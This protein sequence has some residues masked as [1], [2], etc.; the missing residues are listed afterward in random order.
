M[1]RPGLFGLLKEIKS[2]FSLLKVML[3]LF[4]AAV[5]VKLLQ[6][7]KYPAALA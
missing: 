6:C 7:V 2:E 4:E 5:Q 1:E 3:L